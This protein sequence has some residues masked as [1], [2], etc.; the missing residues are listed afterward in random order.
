ACRGCRRADGGALGVGRTARA[1]RVTALGEVACPG[2]GTADG[3][4]R[5]ERVGRA[6]VAHPVAAL[7][8][9]ADVGC[10]AADGRALGVG[11]AAR[12]RA[13]TVLFQV[14]DAR[15]GPT[16]GAGGDEAVGRAVVGAAVAALADVAH[17]S[18][19]PADPRAPGVG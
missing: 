7:R 2:G 11:G 6:V 10:R 14:A 4:G 13:V 17:P 18:C 19:G 3:A 8:H 15:R 9:V 16:R 12:A 5:H 1:R